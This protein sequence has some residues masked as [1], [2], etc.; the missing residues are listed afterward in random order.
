MIAYF[1]ARRAEG[2]FALVVEASA[3]GSAG[4]IVTVSFGLFTR[5]G[6]SATAMAT[7]AVGTVAYLI[8]T[9]A[10]FAYPFVLSLLLALGTYLA[11]SVLERSR[12]SEDA[13]SSAVAAGM[14]RTGSEA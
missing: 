14:D 9:Y 11:G 4:V 13:A 1:L 12:A 10:G 3:F 8:A 7:L 2:V 5:V 6:G